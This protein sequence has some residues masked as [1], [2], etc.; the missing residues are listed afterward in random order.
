MNG[1]GIGFTIG[2]ATTIALAILSP[3]AETIEYVATFSIYGSISGF[4]FHIWQ[5]AL[6]GWKPPFI[7]RR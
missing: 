1:I 6:R 3:G 4:T 7:R 5:M 2:L